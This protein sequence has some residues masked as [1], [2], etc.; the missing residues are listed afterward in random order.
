MAGPPTP[1]GLAGERLTD[2]GVSRR[3][4]L[5]GSTSPASRRAA[6]ASPFGM[7]WHY[8][9]DEVDLPEPQAGSTA[10]SLRNLAGPFRHLHQILCQQ[11]AEALFRP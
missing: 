6:Q 7:S 3:T 11:G 8:V 2:R 10:L 1:P 4:P 5:S 9:V